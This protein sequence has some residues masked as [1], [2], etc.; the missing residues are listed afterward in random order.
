LGLDAKKHAAL[1]F[2]LDQNQLESA[3]ERTATKLILR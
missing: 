3:A 2:P 1:D